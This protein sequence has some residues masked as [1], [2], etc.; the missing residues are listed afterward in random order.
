MFDWYYDKDYIDVLIP[1]Y[2][3][4]ILHQFQHPELSNTIYSSFVVNLWKPIKPR[5][6]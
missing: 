4:K 1:N 2:V 3:D 6:K 5:E